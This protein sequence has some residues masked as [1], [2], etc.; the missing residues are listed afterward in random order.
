M[1]NA[2]INILVAI[3]GGPKTTLRFNNL[4]ERLAELGE[5][6]VK[7]TVMVYYSERIQ[8]KSVME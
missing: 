4:L 3:L 2:F 7:F 6:G 8:T 1:N 5:K